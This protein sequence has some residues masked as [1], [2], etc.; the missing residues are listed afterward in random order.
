MATAGFKQLEGDQVKESHT[1]RRSAWKGVWRKY[2]PV[3]Q[4]GREVGRE[5]VREMVRKIIRQIG[6]QIGRSSWKRGR[7]IKQIVKQI[8]QE[9]ME[10]RPLSDRRPGRKAP[11][12]SMFSR[13]TYQCA[14]AVRAAVT[15]GHRNQAGR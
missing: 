9:F 6:R 3:R 13:G 12:D 14:P 2:T 11:A 15:L 4:V 7:Y 1:C 10:A 5:M 8:M